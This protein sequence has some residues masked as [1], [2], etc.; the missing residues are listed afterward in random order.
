MRLLLPA[1]LK[2]LGTASRDS[3]RMVFHSPQASQ[4]PDHLVVTAPHA[5]QMKEEVDLA[6]T[7]QS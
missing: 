1:P 6:M 7:D 5:W 4:R 2:P 3:S